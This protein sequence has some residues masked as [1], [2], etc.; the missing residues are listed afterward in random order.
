MSLW[1]DEQ[2][3][4]IKDLFLHKELNQ[5]LL[6]LSSCH[7][8]QNLIF[9]GPSGSGKRTRIEALLREIYGDS[10]DKKKKEEI[11]IQ[12]SN[13]KEISFSFITSKDHFEIN[14][15]VLGSN[16]CLVMQKMFKEVVQTKQ[17]D[18]NSKRNFKVIIVYEADYLTKS[19]MHS[20]RRTMEKNVNCVRIFFCCLSP[21]RIINAIK[22]R[23]LQVTIPSPKKAEIEELLR[24]IAK[25]K[26]E[27]SF[28]SNISKIEEECKGNIRKAILMLQTLIQTDKLLFDTETGWETIT[29]EIAEKIKTK[30]T[31]NGIAE[32]REMFYELLSHCIP[33][34]AIIKSVL[35]FL[36]NKGKEKRWRNITSVAA[37]YEERAKNGGKEIFHLEAFCA[38]VMC[39][40]IEE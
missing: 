25:N 17:I 10:I 18:K 37:K 23:C 28:S 7:N 40:Y 15:S 4:R 2:P 35:N 13:G 6:N 16:D 36:L 29:K 3:K 5:N 31:P 34:T 19:A 39:V 12:T 22:S 14:P 20:L 24:K 11:Q 8:I 26:T 21:T 30:K 9:S 33:S 1:I 38:S 27:E 32:I